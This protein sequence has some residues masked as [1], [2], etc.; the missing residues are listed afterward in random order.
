MQCNIESFNNYISKIVAFENNYFKPISLR[1]EPSWCHL[2]A[3][4][5]N[6]EAFATR[7]K[8]ILIKNCSVF[9]AFCSIT[10]NKS[11]VV[12]F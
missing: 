7:S 9:G 11:Q 10:E 1:N 12:N 3:I 8:H 4:V 2:F 5:S 6:T